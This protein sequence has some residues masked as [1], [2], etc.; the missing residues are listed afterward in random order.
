MFQNKNTFSVSEADLI[1]EEYF[2]NAGVYFFPV[3][4]ASHSVLFFFFFFYLGFTA[5]P[6]IFHLYRAN[7]SSK[8]G[9][10]QINGHFSI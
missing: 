9:E 2:D 5:L 8:V 7:S 1:K 3:L 10:N 4:R 6:R